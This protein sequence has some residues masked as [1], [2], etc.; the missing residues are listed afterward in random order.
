MGQVDALG[1]EL[2]GANFRVPGA[3]HLYKA[4]PEQGIFVVVVKGR[5]GGRGGRDGFIGRGRWV[6]R[7]CRYGQGQ[8][9]IRESGQSLVV[10]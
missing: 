7:V 4:K 5:R 2:V 1:D 10:I 8:G 3:V 9:G 6:R